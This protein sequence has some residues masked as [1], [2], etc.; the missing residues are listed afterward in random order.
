MTARLFHYTCTHG[1]N[2]LG[3]GGTLIPVVLQRPDAVAMINPAARALLGMVWAT[4]MAAPDVWALG[5]TRDTIQCD[6]TRYR[7]SVPAASFYRW[8]RVR[9]NMEPAL[10]DALELAPG[11]EPVHWWVAFEPVEGAVYDP[12][13]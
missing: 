5:L 13:P 12:H 2:A 6:R 7:Y 9:H 10:V 8:G 4:D 1:R 11:A 3:P